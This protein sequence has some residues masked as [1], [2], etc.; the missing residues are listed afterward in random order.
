MVKTRDISR[1]KTAKIT[2]LPDVTKTSQHC[3]FQIVSD[4]L[5]CR[6][7]RKSLFTLYTIDEEGVI[8]LT[9]AIG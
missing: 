3:P 5:D 8:N 6:F 4:L 2:M 9:C 7:P 1:A